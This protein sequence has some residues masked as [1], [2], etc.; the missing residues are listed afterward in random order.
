[1]GFYKAQNDFKGALAVAGYGTSVVAL[2]FWLGGFVSGIAF[3]V[4]IA[5]TIVGTMALLMDN[6]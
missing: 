4:V 5:V 6:N 3:G 1:M 2:F